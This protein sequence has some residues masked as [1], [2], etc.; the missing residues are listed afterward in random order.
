ML[1]KK[2][3][4]RKT[5]M[6]QPEENN[7]KIENLIAVTPLS[8]LS[9]N[10]L[11]HGL[12]TASECDDLIRCIGHVGIVFVFILGCIFE[13]HVSVLVVSYMSITCSVFFTEF[14]Q[15]LLL[16]GIFL[17]QRRFQFS[18]IT[19]M[20]MF[21]YIHPYNVSDTF[22]DVYA[23]AGHITLLAISCAMKDTVS[24]IAALIVSTAMC[25]V[26]DRSVLILPITI[27]FGKLC[28]LEKGPLFVYSKNIIPV[29]SSSIGKIY[30][31]SISVY[32]FV[33]LLLL[34]KSCSSR[35][36][37]I[38]FGHVG[39]IFVFNILLFS[40]FEQDILFKIKLVITMAA[41]IDFYNSFSPVSFLN[42]TKLISITTM[43]ISLWLL[44]KQMTPE[45]HRYMVDQKKSHY[46]LRYS[47]III[48]IS[49]C[50]TIELVFASK[51]YM[52][53][54]S[55]LTHNVYIIGGLLLE[56]VRNSHRLYSQIA[57]VLLS[58]EI[59]ASLLILYEENN[60]SWEVSFQII[61]T[62]VAILSIPLNTTYQKTSFDFFIR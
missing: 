38:S 52:M 22:I 20:C 2:G 6:M 30:T 23:G 21:L 7:K 51:T 17:Q 49:M 61:K 32:C 42:I 34:H 45:Y 19:I 35:D 31:L 12:K 50:V 4:K 48:Y 16:S 39:G 53:V 18:P 9:V 60:L 11:V 57:F 5:M 55:N 29:W 25:S 3:C 47:M 27:L 33:N 59:I 15:Y 24:T 26:R 10:L 58:F 1:F 13:N 37:P 44:Q 43:L 36:L 8:V 56:S 14:F 54:F 46:C 41:A 62:I 28:I 40:E